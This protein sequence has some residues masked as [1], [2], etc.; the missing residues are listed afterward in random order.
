MPTRKTP[1]AIKPCDDMLQ[2]I[3]Q[4]CAFLDVSKPMFY[5]F[6]KLGMPALFLGNR[7]HA[8]TAN[9]IAWHRKITAVSI[10]RVGGP[11]PV[12][13]EEEGEDKPEDKPAPIVRAFPR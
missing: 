13:D 10:A 9:L 5:E 12:E 8:N 3:S 11:V 7:Y 2:G 4:I 6:L 1:D